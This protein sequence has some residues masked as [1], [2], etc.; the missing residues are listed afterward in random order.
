MNLL[1][2]SSRTI[3]DAI[4]NLTFM[5]ASRGTSTIDYCLCNSILYKCID[6]FLVMPLTE[7]SDHS[8]IITVLKNSIPLQK[9]TNDNYNWNKLNTR[10]IWDNNNKHKYCN[11]LK[12]STKEVEDIKQRIEGGLIK[13][14]GE[15]IKTFS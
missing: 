5:N 4:G 7:L 9:F 2:L 15:K 6:I 11:I 8:K 14:T 3:G 12:N 1:I 10:F 13:S